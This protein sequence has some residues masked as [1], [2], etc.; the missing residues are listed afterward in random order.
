LSDEGRS[1]AVVVYVFIALTTVTR[2]VILQTH[3]AVREA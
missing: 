3:P 2:N 1:V